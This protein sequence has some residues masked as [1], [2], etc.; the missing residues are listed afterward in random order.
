MTRANQLRKKDTLVKTSGNPGVAQT[1]GPKLVT[2]SAKY[3][4]FSPCASNAPPLSPWNNKQ[5]CRI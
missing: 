1:G 2:P 5:D 3:R 4:P